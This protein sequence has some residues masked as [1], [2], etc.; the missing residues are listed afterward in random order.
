MTELTPQNSLSNVDFATDV[1]SDR[2][3]I[4]WQVTLG[5]SI[6]ILVLTFTFVLSIGLSVQIW[7]MMPVTMIIACIITRG[8]LQAQHYN[9]AALAYAIGGMVVVSVGLT[10][11]N[12]ISAVRIIPFMY[13]IVIFMAGLLLRPSITFLFAFIASILTI[14]IPTLNYNIEII[15]VY[16]VVAIILTFTAA[17]LAAQVTGELYQVTEWALSNYQRERGSRLE[18]FEHREELSRMLKES[19][20][21]LEEAKT[22]AEA[23][24]N[25]RGQ[26]LANMSHEL[27]TPLNAIIGF[28]ETMLKFPMMYDNAEL[29]E[30]YRSDLVQINTSGQHLLTLIN[31]I[32]DL[33]R[34]DAGKLEIYMERVQLQPVIDAVLATANGLVANKP[35]KLE[36]NLPDHLPD[37]WADQNRV[38]Q[39]LLNLYSNS[40]K[41]TDSGTIT[42]TIEDMGDAVQFS[43]SDTGIGIRQEEL[44]AIFEEFRQVSN[45]GGRDPRAGSGLGLAIS[46][47]LL[48]LMNGDIWAESVYGEGSTFHF[49]LRAYRKGSG[50]TGM[51]TALNEADIVHEGK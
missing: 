27:R 29:P 20:I 30:A 6:A 48:E 21:Q 45:T 14:L 36:L 46:R 26:F 40:A 9:A 47:Q 32:L 10:D 13:V 15:E 33:V 38:R 31:D 12:H 5:I 4:L 24:K 17:L 19:N 50:A 18:I 1:K 11:T 22:A 34:V 41:F 35:I 39:V 2:L 7:V 49:T 37:V 16:Q 44:G 28:S 42:L 51:L 3:D 25:F 43:L 23:A 8:L